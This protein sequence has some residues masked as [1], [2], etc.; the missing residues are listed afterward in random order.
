MRNCRMLRRGKSINGITFKQWTNVDRS[1]LETSTQKLPQVMTTVL[2]SL[3]NLLKHDFMAKQQS[4]F[5]KE[6]KK[7]LAPG[8]VLAAIPSL[9]K[10]IYVS[11][12]AAGQYQNRFNF[13]NL[14]F[15]QRDFGVAGEWH[16]FA[17]S[18]GKEPCDGVGGTLKRAETKAS[19]RRPLDNQITTA[20]EL[21]AWAQTLDTSMKIIF[22]PKEEIIENEKFLNERNEGV[23][24]VQGTRSYHSF[25]TLNGETIRVR[26]YSL[27]SNYKDVTIERKEE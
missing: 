15:H 11:D 2:Q 19:L 6:K 1:A 8:G 9:K 25:E 18:H 13:Q 17:T 14:C 10:V 5:V 26:D 7:S 16:F 23:K 12:G 20:K 3:P 4:L 24:T 21:F 27:S 22:V